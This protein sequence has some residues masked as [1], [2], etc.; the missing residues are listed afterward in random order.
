MAHVV[1]RRT[2]LDLLAEQVDDDG[3][4]AWVLPLG[5]SHAML[6]L[7]ALPELRLVEALRAEEECRR[8][9]RGMTAAG[10]HTQ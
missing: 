9:S 6:L 7:A 5:W 1:S 8:R 3:R 2:A 10:L 4:P